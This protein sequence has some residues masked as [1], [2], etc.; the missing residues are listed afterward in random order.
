MLSTVTVTSAVTFATRT[1]FVA[2]RIFAHKACIWRD[3]L[4]F[5]R[6]L[7]WQYRLWHA[8]NDKREIFD[9]VIVVCQYIN[10][11]IGIHRSFGGVIRSSN[12]FGSNYFYAQWRLY[13]V[14]FYLH[15]SYIRLSIPQS[16]HRVDRKILPSWFTTAIP[17]CGA[18]SNSNGG[19]VGNV[20]IVLAYRNRNGCVLQV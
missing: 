5:H 9:W 17:F 14:G 10:V 4:H 2:K 1:K 20:Y 7:Q 13:T 11:Y 12:S 16:Q 6:H 8:A 15:I 3:N 19:V 18:S